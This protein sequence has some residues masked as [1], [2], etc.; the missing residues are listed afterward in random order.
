MSGYLQRDEFAES[1]V[2]TDSEEHLTH[3]AAS[4]PSQDLIWPNQPGD[5]SF[6][7]RPFSDNG[8]GTLLKEAPCLGVRLKQRLHALPSLYV[9]SADFS[10]PTVS[11]FRWLFQGFFENPADLLKPGWVH[12]CL[13]PPDLPLQVLYCH[14]G[15]IHCFA[16]FSKLTFLQFGLRLIHALF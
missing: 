8:H 2:V 16:S 3:A 4:Q 10:Q 14:L 15:P 12:E 9:L 5:V 13:L 6:F 11:L 7:W 1:V